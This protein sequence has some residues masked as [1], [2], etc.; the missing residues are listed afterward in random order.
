MTTELLTPAR[1]R[2]EAR[3]VPTPARRWS[4]PRLALTAIVA[5][6]FAYHALWSAGHVSPAVFIDEL[7]YS[8][9]AQG[10]AAGDGLVLRGEAYAFPAP[11]AA[12]A[13]APAWLPYDHETGYAIAKLLN[14]FLMSLAAVPAYSIARRLVR[15]ELALVAATATVA[16]P[17]MLYHGYLMSEAL[18]YPVFL[19]AVA[20]YLR[21][22]ALGG[23]RLGLAVACASLVAVG[24]RTQFAALP[25]AYLVAL[26]A[27][28]Q[29]GLRRHWVALSSLAV[30]G[31][32]WLATGGAGAGPYLGVALGDYS[33]TEILRWS[34]LTGA[35]VPFGAGLAVFPA[36]ILGLAVSIARPGP[37]V[38]R[39]FGVL[40]VSLGLLVLLQAGVV[41]ALQAE[42]PLERYAIYVVPLLLV[43]ALAYA[44]RG[45]PHRKALVGLAVAFALAV[46][47]VPLSALADYRFSFDSPV[48]S[49]FGTLAGWIGTGEAAAAF[50]GA[51]FLTLVT[52]AATPRRPLVAP[53]LALLVMVALG[54][55]AYAGDRAMTERARAA[56]A[57]PRASW[58]DAAG[59]GRA[60]VLA[61]PGGSRHFGWMLEAWNRSSGRMLELWV[62]PP[63]DAGL[64]AAKA[65]VSEDG[66]LLEDGRPRR[67]G[68]LVLTDYGTR[69]EIEGDVLKRPLPG[70]TLVRTPEAPR[71]LSAAVGLFADGWASTRL[72]Y[73]V[74]PAPSGGHYVLELSLPPGHAPREVVV[75]IRGRAGRPVLVSPGEPVHVELPAAGEL[76]LTSA[77]FDHLDPGTPSPRLVS[78]RVDR[79]EYVES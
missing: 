23:P 15:P 62:P 63:P 40:A 30:F 71:V 78:V 53:G 72:V 31:A 35:L 34:A 58:L 9:L 76:E 66:V 19:F 24:T 61:L 79:L 2:T 45:A 42:R 48:L 32:A 75:A 3:P 12:I 65:H 21:E 22:L 47:L 52:V 50:A 56:F 14:A 1:A 69:L 5:A 20:V 46:W 18:A 68:L 67:A 36:A 51:G 60:D 17:A 11:L 57:P 8:K 39:A 70:L 44:E 6:A 49:A 4:S 43:A 33:T 28:R 77:S 38:E 55:L 59:V 74:W 64:P 37:P 13:Q 26:C 29:G 16:A 54:A 73:R 25:L 7:L 27:T 10:I 41:A